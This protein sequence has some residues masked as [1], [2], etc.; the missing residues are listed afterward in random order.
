MSKLMQVESLSKAYKEKKKVSFLKSEYSEIQAVN[1]VSFS[2]EAGD[3]IGLVG[4][5]GAGKSTLLSLLCGVMHPDEGKILYMGSDIESNRK[6]YVQQIGVLFAGKTRLPWGMSV[7]DGV[8]WNGCFY[9]IEKEKAEKR[10]QYLA[11]VLEV[12]HLLDREPR[13][14]SLGEKMKMELLQAFIHEPELVFLDEPTIGVDVTVKETIRDFLLQM[15]KLY[16]LSVIMTSHD[17]ND[18]EK[19]CNRII[20]M[21]QG[22]CQE[23]CIK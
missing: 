1:E 19:V 4:P 9:G 20:L 7:R 13:N 2:V 23:V 6:S 15:N 22:R 3:M 16:N 14:L 21:E 8:L 11:E 18:I 17:K 12:S 5:N 10:M